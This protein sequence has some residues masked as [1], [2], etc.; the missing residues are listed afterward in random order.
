MAAN[1]DTKGK[2]GA[3]YRGRFAPTPSGPLHL[4]SL[5]TAVASFLQARAKGGQWILRI[6]D[7][8]RDRA[9]AAATAHILQQL[10]DHGLQWDG[11]IHF[12]RQHEARYRKALIE[13]RQKLR[14]YRCDCSRA[15]LKQEST[16]GADGLIYSG[17]CRR[18]HAQ[19]PAALRVE[20]PA[21]QLA[22]TDRWLG[23]QSRNAINQIGDFVLLR[24]DGQIAYQL[25]C[26]IDDAAL[27]VT[28]VIRGTDLLE[29]SFRQMALMRLLQLKPPTYGHLPLLTDA[30][31]RKLSKQNHADP[32]D[33]RRATS[34]LRRV[35]GMLGQHE[36]ASSSA[37]TVN[38]LITLSIARWNPE[39]VPRASQIET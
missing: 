4:G 33:S 6:D 9:S 27:G 11:S 39:R 30:A 19:E 13:A 25:A 5:Y 36:A 29:S 18:R 10:Q 37:T 14:I 35:L 38:D 24:R 7:L 12:Q 22:M 17:R 16:P 3:N 32:I 31:G 1:Q 8:D 28:E 20:I 2:I 23:P 21:Q 15:R 26:V 34:N